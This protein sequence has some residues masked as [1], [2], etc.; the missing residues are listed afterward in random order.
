MK[1]VHTNLVARDWRRLVAFYERACGCV[2]VF[3]ERDLAGA[4]VERGSGVPGARIQGIHLRL[5][6]LGGGGPTLEVF[7]YADLVSAG[8]PVAN[9]V[10]FGHIAFAVDDV[11]AARAAVLDAGGSALGTIEV[12]VIPSVG[13]ITWTYVRDPEGNIIELQRLDAE[14]STVLATGRG[15][16]ER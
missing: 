6:G 11:A 1:Y 8:E 4:T 15:E 16:P 5:P 3:P 10:G 7:Q 14:P 2:R 9:R 12:T 13:R